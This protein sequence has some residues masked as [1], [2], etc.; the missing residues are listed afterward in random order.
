MFHIIPNDD[1]SE[2]ADGPRIIKDL[3]VANGLGCHEVL[4]S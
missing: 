4:R 2:A 3:N 1:G